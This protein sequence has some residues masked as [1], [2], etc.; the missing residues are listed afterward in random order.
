MRYV[1]ELHKEVGLNTYN[2][3]LVKTTD[4]EEDALLLTHELEQALDTFKLRK[5]TIYRT[6]GEFKFISLEIRKEA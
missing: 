3:M 4:K 5:K 1:I 6:D 2:T